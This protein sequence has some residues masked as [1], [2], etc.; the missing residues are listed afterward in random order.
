MDRKRMPTLRPTRI[1]KPVGIVTSIPANTT[2]PSGLRI[3][4]PTGGIVLWVV[5]SCAVATSADNYRAGMTA[6][7]FRIQPKGIREVITDG[8]TGQFLQFDA[9]FPSAGFRFPLNIKVA[10]ND[11]WMVYVRNLST[12]TAFT[13]ELAFAIAEC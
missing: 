11:A 13:P 5:G 4:W 9:A 10:Q 1:I 2:S 6:L 12:G 8:Q 3:D 7:G